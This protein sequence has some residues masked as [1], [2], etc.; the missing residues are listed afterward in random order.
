MLSLAANDWLSGTWLCQDKLG[1]VG[2]V[3]IDQGAAERFCPCALAKD[4]SEEHFPSVADCIPLGALRRNTS[5][6]GL[7]LLHQL[8][9]RR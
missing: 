2:S 9:V 1:H 4:P 6:S 5:F 7:L 3:A 8:L